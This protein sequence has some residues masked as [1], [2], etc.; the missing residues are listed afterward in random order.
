MQNHPAITFMGKSL[1]KVMI[2]RT[3]CWEN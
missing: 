1:K 3:Q 2:K